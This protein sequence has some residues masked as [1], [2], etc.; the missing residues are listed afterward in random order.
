MKFIRGENEE[1]ARKLSKNKIAL[2]PSARIL[3]LEIQR[4]GTASRGRLF[5]I[6]NKKLFYFSTQY[7]NAREG[8]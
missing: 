8:V 7:T 5:R 6:R 2:L 3:R 4:Y 1:A